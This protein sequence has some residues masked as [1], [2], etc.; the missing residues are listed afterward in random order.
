MMKNQDFE[1]GHKQ[2]QQIM[3]KCK[4][5][6]II[7]MAFIECQIKIGQIE[8]ANQGL[9]ELE[10]ELGQN[11]EYFYLKGLYEYYNG[12][13]VNCKRILQEAL[14]RDPDNSKSQQLM[15]QLKK[16]DKFKE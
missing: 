12:N 11:M 8:Q 13:T 1:E 15:R 14:R 6:S 3:I 16:V 7:K 9:K 10:S 2:L 4:E 5:I